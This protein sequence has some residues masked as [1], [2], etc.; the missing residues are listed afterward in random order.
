MFYGFG[1][2]RAETPQ[3]AR[4]RAVTRKTRN[5]TTATTPDTENQD[6]ATQTTGCARAPRTAAEIS[7]TGG[8]ASGKSGML[9]QV[10]CREPGKTPGS[11]PAANRAHESGTCVDDG[12]VNRDE[13]PDRTPAAV[14][15]PDA[16]GLKFTSEAETRRILLAVR[17]YLR[18]ARVYVALEY[19]GIHDPGSARETLNRTAGRVAVNARA[20][21]YPARL[22]SV[23]QLGYWRGETGIGIA[24]EFSTRLATVR[25]KQ[26]W[27]DGVCA[28]N[29]MVVR[30]N[31]PELSRRV[32]HI[33]RL[34]SEF[35]PAA[36]ELTV[37]LL[38]QVIFE[39]RSPGVV[40]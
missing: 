40:R 8:T 14:N 25:C 4:L 13:D 9:A 16:Y 23:E 12:Q 37:F 5:A 7:H 1:F 17:S 22:R 36:R 19:P 18:A 21:A 35:S 38:R 30:V 32:A 24:S 27:V 2:T 34:P 33:V 28:R 15:V 29:R 11:K 3:Q 6:H 31:W 20:P 10:V 26:D 39:T